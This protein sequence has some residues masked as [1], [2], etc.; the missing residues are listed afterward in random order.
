MCFTALRDYELLMMFQQEQRRPPVLARVGLSLAG[1]RRGHLRR[2]WLADLAGDPVSGLVPSPW[3]R[4][5]LAV[6]YLL[7]GLRLR[8]HDTVGVLWVPVDWVLG[9]GSRTGAAIAAATGTMAVG[10]DATGGLDRLLGI[11]VAA[12]TTTAASLSGLTR[13]LRRVRGIELAAQ[14]PRLGG[15]GAAPRTAAAWRSS[16]RTSCAVRCCTSGTSPPAPTSA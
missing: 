13:W 8:L 2:A 14:V 6:G 5:A 1:P 3:W 10:I 11:G 16:G 4:R 9:A 12:C 7:A 15:P